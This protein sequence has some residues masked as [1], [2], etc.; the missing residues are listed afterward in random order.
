MS[1]KEKA[2]MAAA[3]EKADP[4]LKEALRASASERFLG[5]YF[6]PM[7]LSN[8][9]RIVWLVIYLILIAGAAYGASQ[10]ELHFEFDFFISTEHVIYEYNQLQKKY[11]ATAGVEPDQIY[12]DNPT[13]PY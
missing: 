13:I 4:A 2:D 11:F 7:V 5:K 3:I 1:D 6:A 12:I 10:V 9:G 8:I